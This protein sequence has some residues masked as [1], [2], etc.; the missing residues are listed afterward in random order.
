MERNEFLKS[1]GLGVALICTGS[2]LSGCD[3]RKTDP[4]PT[5]EGGGTVISTINISIQ[6]LAVGSFLYKNGVMFIRI[7]TGNKASSFV[8]TQA[9]CTHHGGVLN[10][11]ASSNLIQCSSHFAQFTLTGTTISQPQGGGE[12]S[13][14]RIYPTSLVGNMLNASL[15]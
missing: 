12:A 10:W 3:S 13:A 14:L 15:S 2:C 4:A 1:L 8:A 9:N 11:I 6:L 5:P 7:A